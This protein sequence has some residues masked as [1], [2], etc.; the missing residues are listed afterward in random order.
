MAKPLVDLL[1]S[2]DPAQSASENPLTNIELDLLILSPNF[3]FNPKYLKILF[4]AAQCISVG[5]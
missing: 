1:S 3:V 2:T 5:A 4:T